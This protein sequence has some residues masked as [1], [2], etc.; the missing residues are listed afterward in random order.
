VT[1]QAAREAVAPGRDRTARASEILATAT[2]LFARDGY[3]AVGMR[4]VALE[5]GI[6]TSSLYHHF[7][8]KEAILY[9]IALEVTKDFVESHIG[10]LDGPVPI[11]ERLSALLRAHVV[12][13]WERRREFD[14]AL[15]EVNELAPGH[16]EEVQGHRRRYQRR[17]RDVIAEGVDAGQFS[18]SDPG[19]AT[20][21]LLDMINGIHRWFRPEQGTIEDLAEQYVALAMNLLGAGGKPR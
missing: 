1:Q 6:R 13:F 7:P 8:S 11:P 14:V 20:L 5:I 4:A 12:Y 2:E 19:V 21:A 15:R 18:V 17:I 16:Y 9:E 3:H 10:M